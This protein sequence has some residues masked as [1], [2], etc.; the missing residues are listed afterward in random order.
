MFV[1]MSDGWARE[2]GGAA[3]G[4]AL[5]QSWGPWEGVGWSLA[6]AARLWKVSAV[7]V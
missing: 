7:P 4:T 3:T 1:F 2:A 6:R 5:S